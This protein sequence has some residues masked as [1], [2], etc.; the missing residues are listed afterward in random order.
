MERGL[1]SEGAGSSTHAPR[2]GLCPFSL[3]QILRKDTGFGICMLACISHVN[4]FVKWTKE[5][6]PRGVLWGQGEALDTRPCA[7]NKT[8]LKAQ[9]FF[10]FSVSSL[11]NSATFGECSHVAPAKYT[12]ILGTIKHWPP[13][14]ATQIRN[15]IITESSSWPRGRIMH[16]E[17]ICTI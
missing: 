7:V 12:S 11:M 4:S 5:N 9:T 8:T 17:A 14:A 10:L 1:D 6:Q 16:V 3:L 15:L 13:D 2:L